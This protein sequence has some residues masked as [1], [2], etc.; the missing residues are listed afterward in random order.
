MPP[1]LANHYAQT[2]IGHARFGQTTKQIA[3]QTGFEP[4]EVW[5]WLYI[6]DCLMVREFANLHNPALELLFQGIEKDQL[7]HSALL[8][9]DMFLRS[10]NQSLAEIASKRQVKITTVKEHLLE[11]AI[12]L[13]DPRPLFKLVLSRQT[14]VELDKRAPQLVTEWKFDQTLEKQ[15]NIDFFEFRMYQIMRS[16]E[17]GS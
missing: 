4:D 12:L 7:S 6:G 10:R 1:Q 16:R 9:R 15:L 5:L 11:C 17:N 14:I 13:T 2:L 8:T 3:D